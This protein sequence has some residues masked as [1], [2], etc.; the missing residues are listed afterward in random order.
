MCWT[1]LR[2]FKKKTDLLLRLKSKKENTISTIK[3]YNSIVKPHFKYLLFNNL[4]F[5]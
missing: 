3:N 1:L 2:K 4:V 5:D